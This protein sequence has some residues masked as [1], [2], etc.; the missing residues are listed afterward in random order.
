MKFNKNDFDFSN[1]P[2]NAKKYPTPIGSPVEKNSTKTEFP[3]RLLSAKFEEPRRE[4]N[5]PRMIFE[6]KIVQPGSR[7]NGEVYQVSQFVKAD[8]LWQDGLIVL[9][10]EGHD[11]YDLDD[12]GRFQFRSFAKKMAALLEVCGERD[13]KAPFESTTHLCERLDALIVKQRDSGGN[14]E[15]KT[16]VAEIKAFWQRKSSPEG[17]DVS[18]EVYQLG[19]IKAFDPAGWG[20]GRPV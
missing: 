17:K 11:R 14:E 13:P 12:E 4:G 15:S 20:Q 5:D 18:F 6:L 19:F 1:Q 3:V 16:F 8:L 2:S 10:A 7:L 9:D